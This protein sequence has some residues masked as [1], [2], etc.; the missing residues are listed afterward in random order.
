M[1]LSRAQSAAFEKAR[2]LGAGG[3]AI[4]LSD[5]AVRALV[6]ITARDLD[7]PSLVGLDSMDAREFYEIAPRDV[8]LDGVISEL[9]AYDTLLQVGPPDTDTYFL[10]L[11]A[12]HRARLKFANIFSL[13]AIPLLEQVG[14]RGLLQYGDLSAEA[15]G[16]LLILRK[17]MYDIDNRA[18][19]ETGYLFEPVMA[20][21]MGGSPIPASSSPVRRG[22]TGRGRQVDCLRGK[23]AYEIKIRVTI[24]A[25]GQGRWAEELS[26]PADCEASGY[27]PNLV[28][29]DGTENPKLSELAEA[30]VGH[31]GRAF[32]GADA[33]AHLEAEAGSTMSVFI[34][35]YIRDPFDE[36][37][38]RTP[39]EMPE[40]RLRLRSDTIH[41]QIGSET[42]HVDRNGS[43]R[44][45][46]G[47]RLALE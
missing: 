47:P 38:Q 15:L 46:A 40:L 30:F 5:S 31:G 39:A 16:S 21:A 19:Q 1:A 7:L 24:A 13:Q 23:D 37:L 43:G 35:K 26:F 44:T 34:E 45:L 11:A 17:W 36:L 12:L 14:P 41:L 29:L 20:G 9:D 8:S 6:A 25:S 32:V 22:G 18:A 27:I 10:S 2:A 4:S 3:Q 33:W 42:L 28:V